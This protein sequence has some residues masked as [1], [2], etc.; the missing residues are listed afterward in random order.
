MVSEKWKMETT[1]KTA[2]EME[3]ILWLELFL[4]AHIATAQNTEEIV[5]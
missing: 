5:A 1:V 2:Q 3:E 4:T